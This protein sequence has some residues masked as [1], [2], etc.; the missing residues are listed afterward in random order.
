M[1]EKEPISILLIE[2][3]RHPALL[4]WRQIDGGMDTPR[5]IEVL[6]QR[7]KSEIYRLQEGAPGGWTII[8][9]RCLSETG[10]LERVIYEEI[11]P[12]LPISQLRYYGCLEEAESEVWIFLEDAGEQSFS[13]TDDSH[14]LLAADWLGGLHRSARQ[15]DAAEMLPLRDPAYYFDLMRLGRENIVQNLEN[16]ALTPEYMDILKSVLTQMETLESNSEKLLNLCQGFPQTMVH[17]DFQPKNIRVKAGAT[18][19]IMYVMDWEMAGWGIPVVD[20]APSHGMSSSAELDLSAYLVIAQ[21]FWPNLDMPTL[22]FALHIGCVF[23]RVAAVY[24]SSWGLSYPWVEKPVLSMEI[25][26]KEL[27]HALTHIFGENLGY[28]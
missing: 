12:L 1:P 13:P 22:R 23:R 7:K 27:A 21:D 20:L 14:R 6:Q 26:Q 3:D 17:A 16:P 5:V 24:W 8:A 11:L 2:F 15:T 9:K 10:K 18:G 28:G 4:A 19:D 25:Y